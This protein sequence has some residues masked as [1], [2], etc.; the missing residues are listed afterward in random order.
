LVSKTDIQKVLRILAREYSN[1]TTEL[2]YQ[3]PFEL[4]VATVLSA[5]STDI[6]VNLV[7]P[8]LFK[9][10]PNVKTLAAAKQPALEKEIRSIGLSKQKARNLTNLAQQL[11]TKHQ[12]NIPT[13][14]TQLTKLPG[15]GRKTANVVLAHA[16]GLP[17]FPVD[18]HVIRVSTRLGIAQGRNAIEIERQLCTSIP[19]KD[20]RLASDVQIL[21]GRRVCKQ[22]PLCQKCVLQKKCN[23]FKIQILGQLKTS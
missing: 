3:N 20:W 10:Y 13:N 4:L 22:K 5:Q 6:K 12:G 15:V 16:F 19:Q 1:A 9:R 21:H 18:R 8:N 17:G 14:I 11:I 2:E 7:T 23:Y